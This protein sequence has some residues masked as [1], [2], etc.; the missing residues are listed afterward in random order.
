MLTP[1]DPG[2]TPVTKVGGVPWWPRGQPRPRCEHGHSMAFMAQ[3]RLSDVPTLADDGALLSFHYCLTCTYDG[4]MSFGRND[5]ENRGYAI[6]LLNNVEDVPPDELG[7]VSPGCLP[8]MRVAFS[9]AD[10]VLDL[11]DASALELELPP[12]MFSVGEDDFDENVG[13]GLIHV[14]RSKLGGWPHWQQSPEWPT[15]LDGRRMTFVM[16]LDWE[17]GEASP[18][19]GGGYAYLFVC[20]RECTSREADLVIQTT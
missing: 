20:G 3:A 11:E 19:G 17:L 9:D 16:Q 14:A 12:E 15:C 13:L 8:E 10:E 6:T 7:V 2:P 5:D 4:R 1:G 18:W